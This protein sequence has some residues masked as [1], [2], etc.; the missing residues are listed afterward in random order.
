MRT[1]NASTGRTRALGNAA[2][3]ATRGKDARGLV[4][5]G[6]KDEHA[7]RGGVRHAGANLWQRAQGAQRAEYRNAQ[8]AASAGRRHACEA[9]GKRSLRGQPSGASSGGGHDP[10]IKYLFR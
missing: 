9:R 1:S 7:E 4:T 2:W 5:S 3:E 8:R 10:P 6:R